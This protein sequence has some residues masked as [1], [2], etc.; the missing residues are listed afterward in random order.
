MGLPIYPKFKERKTFDLKK[1]HK[2]IGR[3][4]VI[5]PSDSDLQ[6]GNFISQLWF[7]DE[8]NVLWLIAEWD[9]LKFGTKKKKK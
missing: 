8:K 4:L 6:E 7:Q 3:L 1:L 9:A 5:T 2:K